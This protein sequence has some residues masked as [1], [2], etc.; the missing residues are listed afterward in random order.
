[1]LSN[2]Q[3]RAAL[4][5]ADTERVVQLLT[6]ALEVMEEDCS[7]ARRR[8]EDACALVGG[9]VVERPRKSMLAHWQVERAQRYIREHL[10]GHL[11]IEEVARSVSLSASHFSRAFKATVGESY[12]DFITHA[13]I[14]LAKQL[15]LTTDAPI[16]QIALTCG[17][18]DQSHLT[19]LFSRSV[20]LPPRAW[21]RRWI[22]T[23]MSARP[24]R[25]ACSG[26]A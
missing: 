6:E 20:G 21:R 16:S 17:L 5:R 25:M 15:L 14:E 24:S 13:R 2:A 18:A 11:R 23:P 10:E 7:G 8:I 1:M 22:E 9:I 4:V 26:Q 12:S 19:R 3:T